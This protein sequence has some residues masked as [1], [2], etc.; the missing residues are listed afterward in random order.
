MLA[1][2]LHSLHKGVRA[3]AKK[4]IKIGVLQGAGPTP[5]YKWNVAILN[6][7]LDEVTAFLTEPQYEHM[8]MQVKELAKEDDPSHPQ[9]VS[10]DAIEDFFELSDKGGV[11]GNKSV[12]VFFGI[13]KHERAIVILGGIKKETNGQTPK[14]TKTA[15]RRRWR[16][17]QNGDYGP[18]QP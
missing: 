15:M 18:F 1:A 14:G 11:L 8:A 9:T 16:K 13:S 3:V 5:G 7:A 6:L 4:Q 17:Y 12:R 10:V 2:G